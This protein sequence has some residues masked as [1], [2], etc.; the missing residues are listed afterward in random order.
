MR[1]KG[2]ELLKRKRK[3]KSSNNLIKKKEVIAPRPL[4]EKPLPNNVVSAR[5]RHSNLERI[6]GKLNVQSFKMPGQNTA[7][8]AVSRENRAAKTEVPGKKVGSDSKIKENT[9]AKKPLTKRYVSVS[10]TDT[11]NYGKGK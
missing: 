1:K 10:M 4:K 3:K 8:R 7:K 5:Q 6:D 2:K 9:E 11:D